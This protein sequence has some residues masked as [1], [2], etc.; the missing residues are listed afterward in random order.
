MARRHLVVGNASTWQLTRARVACVTAAQHIELVGCALAPSL[1]Q[2]C[3]PEELFKARRWG[4][5]VYLHRS[6]WVIG[7]QSASFDARCVR[8]G[9]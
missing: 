5:L 8:T 9:P 6:G 7:A 3:G 1:D 2:C 4:L